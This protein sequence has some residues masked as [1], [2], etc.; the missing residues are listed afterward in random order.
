MVRGI[1]FYDMQIADNIFF[2]RMSIYPCC[3]KQFLINF[4]PHTDCI[5]SPHRILAMIVSYNMPLLNLW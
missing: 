5:H 3:S 4:G 1:F 2:D